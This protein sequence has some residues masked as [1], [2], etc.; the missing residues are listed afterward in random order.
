MN[1]NKVSKILFSL[2]FVLQAVGA[3]KYNAM[4]QSFDSN[5]EQEINVDNEPY[6]VLEKNVEGKYKRIRINLLGDA[7]VKN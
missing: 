6:I 4:R 2:F 1:K 3:F 7:N 5:Q